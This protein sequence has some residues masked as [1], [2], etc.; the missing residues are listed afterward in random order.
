MDL[1]I[2]IFEYSQL[3]ILTVLCTQADAIV[4]TCSMPILV[5]LQ[6]MTNLIRHY[7]LKPFKIILNLVLTLT[8]TMVEASTTEGLGS[9]PLVMPLH[10]EVAVAAPAMTTLMLSSGPLSATAGKLPARPFSA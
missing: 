2:I 10:V 6:K 5:Q 9:I 4:L 8:L 1:I 3:S 7:W